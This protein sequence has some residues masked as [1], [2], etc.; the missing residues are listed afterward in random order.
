MKIEASV[1]RRQSA[2]Y[3]EDIDSEYK[4]DFLD[5]HEVEDE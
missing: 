4:D 5:H 1:K 3:Q 2:E